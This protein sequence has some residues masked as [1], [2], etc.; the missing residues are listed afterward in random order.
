MPCINVFYVLQSAEPKKPLTSYM[1]FAAYYRD[2]LKREKPDLAQ[3]DIIKA[4]GEKWNGLNAAEKK[5]RTL[6]CFGA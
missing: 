6:L 1:H 3:K 2:V 4:I 5:V